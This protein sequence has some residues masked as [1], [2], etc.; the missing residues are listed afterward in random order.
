MIQW[1]DEKQLLTNEQIKNSYFF[2]FYESDE[3]P[4]PGDFFYRKYQQAQQVETVS[5]TEQLEHSYNIPGIKTI[6]IVVYRYHPNTAF[7]LQT[8]LVTKNIV[9]GDGVLKS[10]DFSILVLVIL[11][12]C[13]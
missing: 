10:Q 11:I 4:N 3:Y 8:Y 1:G 12:F 2:N 9:V 6:K 7:I 5:I 13:L